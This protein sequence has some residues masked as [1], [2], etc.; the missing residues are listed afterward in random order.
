MRREKRYAAPKRIMMSWPIGASMLSQGH[1]IGFLYNYLI[2]HS[3][4][5]FDLQPAAR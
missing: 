2:I 5:Q 3:F 1:R 4:Y